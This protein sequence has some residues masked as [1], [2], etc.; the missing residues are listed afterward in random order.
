MATGPRSPNRV[1]KS[2]V[3]E[4]SFW[5]KLGTLGR[6]KKLREIEEIQQEGKYAIDSPAFANQYTA[7]PEDYIMQDTEQRAVLDPKSE[8]DPEFIRLQE[9]LINWINDELADQR[10]IVKTLDQDLYDGQVLHKLLEKLANKKLD[11]P[12][13]TQSEDGQKLKLHKVLT[14]VNHTLGFH[15]KIPKWSVESIHS[16]NLV[17][18]VHLLVSLV[19]HFRAPI[20]LPENVWVNVVIAQQNQGQINAQKFQEQLTSEYNDVG[21]K[22]EKDAF[23]ALFDNAPE[24]LAIVKRSLITFVNKHLGKLNIEVADLDSE[25]KDGVY[26]CFLMGL[27]GGFFVPLYDYHV[28]PKTQEQ[29]VNNVALSFELMQDIGLP[30]PKARPEG[31]FLL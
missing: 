18:I 6:K 27:L 30:M 28:T 26:L 14:G 25:F 19:R 23:D 29:M 11:V 1:I 7:S 16:K 10:I 20:R 17:A 3:K 12:E 13:V 2:D 31:M 24:K 15:H 4:E 22:C 9:V 5:D 8:K 21:M